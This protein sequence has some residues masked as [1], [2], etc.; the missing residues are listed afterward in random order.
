MRAMSMDLEEA[1]D[2]VLPD[3]DSYLLYTLRSEVSAAVEADSL[4]YGHYC[5]V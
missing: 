5:G 1:R 3:R 4:D 2:P